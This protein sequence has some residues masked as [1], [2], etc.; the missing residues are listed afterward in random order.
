MNVD[1]LIQEWRDVG[2]RFLA[3]FWCDP[4]AGHDMA[5]D[6]KIGPRHFPS[7]SMWCVAQS[8]GGCA[9]AGLLEP[10]NSQL[11]AVAKFAGATLASTAGWGRVIDDIEF[12]ESSAAG[13]ESYAR[14]L[15]GFETRNRLGQILQ[16]CYM[17]VVN[18]DVSLDVIEACLVERARRAVA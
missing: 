14:L 11:R 13:L 2:L 4:I 18:L 16:S 9:T 15:A 6:F 17:D 3:G 12:L 1:R 8:L 7:S 5:V 10:T